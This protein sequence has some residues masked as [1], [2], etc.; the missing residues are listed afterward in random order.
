[1]RQD[2]INFI[3]FS[4]YRRYLHQ[5]GGVWVGAPGLYQLVC[6]VGQILGPLSVAAFGWAAERKQATEFP[7]RR[8]NAGL[9]FLQ[10]WTVGSQLP[11]WLRNK[12]LVY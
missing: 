6:V 12:A 8:F 2:C 11:L 7:C 1:M 9:D 10:R 5:V 4:K 3:E